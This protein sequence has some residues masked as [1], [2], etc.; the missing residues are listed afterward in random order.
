MGC[1]LNWFAIGL[2]SYSEPSKV[3]RRTLSVLMCIILFL[4][5]DTRFPC[6]FTAQRRVLPIHWLSTVKHVSRS[7]QSATKTILT[8]SL[9][10]SILE[11][12]VVPESCS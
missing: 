7:V 2:G 10:W 4:F 1:G 9:E 6:P 11:R 8:L 3:K 5:R 12:S